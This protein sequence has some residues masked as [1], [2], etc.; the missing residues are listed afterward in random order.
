MN[1]LHKQSAVRPYSHTLRANIFGVAAVYFAQ[2]LGYAT[3]MTALPSFARQWSLS[4]AT[5]SVILLGTC[6][7][8]A[9]GSI[10]A[11]TI[12][13]KAS[14]RVAVSVGLALEAAALLGIAIAPTFPLYL[15]AVFVYGIGLGS[16]DAAQNMQG[17]STE[18]RLGKPLLGRFYAVSTVS[19]ILGALAVSGSLKLTESPLVALLFA[20]AL[21]CLV[22]VL[23]R[24]VLEDKLP[25]EPPALATESVAV[26]TP[27]PAQTGQPSPKLAFAVFGAVGFVV[28]GAFMLDSAVSSW[29]T[30]YLSQGLLAPAAVAPLGYAL[31]QGAVLIARLF[32]D[33]LELR[34]GR[35]ALARLSIL[36]GLMASLVIAFVPTILGAVLG[37]GLAGLATGALVPIAFSAAG[38]LV[39]ERSD[40]VVARVNLFNYAGALLGAVLLGLV[41]EGRSLGFAFLLPGLGLLLVLPLI[42]RLQGRGNRQRREPHE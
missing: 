20:A 5:I 21:A 8:A 7:L 2:G 27:N 24:S 18:K 33:F 28:L 40:E 16:I 37:F 39:P 34:I 26:T 36:V 13:A 22:S 4:E 30:M 42:G 41:G 38:S 11:D 1:S 17:V 35:L 32:T 19:M 12:A 31:Y 9:V 23:A 6:L 3:V 25:A 15:A 10:V 29:S 14:S